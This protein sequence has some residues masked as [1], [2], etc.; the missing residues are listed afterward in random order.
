MSAWIH[1][2][3]SVAVAL[4]LLTVVGNL[5]CKAVLD[6]SGLS[7]AM[8]QTPEAE[9]AEASANTPRVGRLI[10][11]L[12]RLMI[13]SGLIIGAWEILAAV[14]ALKTVARFKD[15]DEK[16]NAEYFLVGSLFSVVWAIIVTQ[17]WIAYDAAYGLDLVGRIAG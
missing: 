16:L 4:L 11:H 13:A 8:A 2:A 10:G 12:E 17:A 3:G 5:A 1:F 15:L 9:G 7:R 14:V 6:W